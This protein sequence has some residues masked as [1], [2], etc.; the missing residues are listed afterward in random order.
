MLPSL[1]GASNIYGCGM[2]ELG[3]SF[4][5]EQLVIDNDIIGMTKYAKRGITVSPET[6]AYESIKDVGI[7]NDFLGYFDT[8]RNFTVPSHPEVFDR[9]MYDAWKNE[10][11]MDVTD[12]AHKKVMK[13]LEDHNPTP[14]DEYARKEIDR[15]LKEADK[16]YATPH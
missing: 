1:A 5:A 11:S 15:I 8:L 2:L 16:R 6:L 13:I 12:M 4:S 3:M 9:N 7:G 10:G 14:I